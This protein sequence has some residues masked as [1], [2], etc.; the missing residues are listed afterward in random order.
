[1]AE[2]YN[3]EFKR[4][5]TN[6]KS[7][8]GTEQLTNKVAERVD[9]EL[10]QDFQI[11]SSRIKS[12]LDPD[13]IRIFWA[14][15]LPGDPE[16]DFLNT[17][18]GRNTFHKYVFV[19][20]WQMN[21]YIARYGLKPSRCIVLR[22][23]IDKFEKKEKEYDGQIKLIYHTTPHRGLNILTP[24]FDKLCEKYDNI[25]LDVFSSFA[26]YGWEQRD[27]EYANVFE[28]LDKNP[29]VNNH[30]TQPQEV[31]RTALE[32]SHIFAYPSIWQETSCLSLIEAMSSQNLCVHSNY[33]GLFETASHWT[34]QY[35][36][37]E[38]LNDHAAAFYNMLDL[39]IENY[40]QMRLN[41]TPTKVY[42]DTFYSWEN[43]KP[44][45]EALLHSLKAS[46]KDRSLPKETFSYT[47]I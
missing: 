8:G 22:N 28:A 38:D 26:I 19:S 21:G 3:G 25:T 24:V 34:N 15:D 20:H 45:W 23:F 29:K 6:E 13:K 40:D 1:M 33:G 5:E 31:I 42:A 41:T 12:D 46:V 9:N 32:K 11:I 16:S 27:T 37:S 2:I 39:T 7:F 14:H 18:M 47:T 4:N 10:L 35:Q 30:G 44:E 43:R 36:F 17:E